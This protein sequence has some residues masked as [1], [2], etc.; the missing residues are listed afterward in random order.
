MNFNIDKYQSNLELGSTVSGT[1][2]PANP[3]NHTP[4]RNKATKPWQTT[5]P[6]PQRWKSYIFVF[7]SAQRIL[8]REKDLK[9]KTEEFKGFYFSFF[10][11]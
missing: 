2:D 5:P 6:K 1:Q 4:F 9:I 3:F 10:V 11:W 7:I 8:K